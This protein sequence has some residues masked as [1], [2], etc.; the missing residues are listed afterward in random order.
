MNELLYIS[1]AMHYEVK[2][3]EMYG[4]IGSFGY[5]AQSFDGVG[6]IQAVDDGFINTQIKIMASTLGVSTD[7]VRLISKEEYDQ[8]TADD[9]DGDCSDDWD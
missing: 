2:D 8:E 3:S 5:A 4:G 7:K 1:V 9:E 6:N